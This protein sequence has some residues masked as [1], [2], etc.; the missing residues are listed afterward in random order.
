MR[1][2]SPFVTFPGLKFKLGVL[3]RVVS[4]RSCDYMGNVSARFAGLKF[5][6]AFFKRARIFSSGKLSI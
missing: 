1:D 5:Q 2:F 4:R 3:V 6:P